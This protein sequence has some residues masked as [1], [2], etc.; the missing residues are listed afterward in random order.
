MLV[1]NWKLKLSIRAYKYALI[2]SLLA[3][4]PYLNIFLMGFHK[5]ILFIG[6]PSFTWAFVHFFMDCKNTSIEKRKEHILFAILSFIGYPLVTYI[7]GII[8]GLSLKLVG[9][10]WIYMESK[11]TYWITMNFPISLITHWHIWFG[12]T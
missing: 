12:A 6:L 1:D 3:V 10:P 4:I 11:E 9:Y 8:I 7:Y 2:V 5:P